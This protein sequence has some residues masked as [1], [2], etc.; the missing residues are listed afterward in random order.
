MSHLTFRRLQVVHDLGFTS[1]TEVLRL[2]GGVGNRLTV[3]FVGLGA[4]LVSKSVDCVV[5]GVEI[6]SDDVENVSTCC[7][8]GRFSILVKFGS[9]VTFGN[10]IPVLL[11]R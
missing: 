2:K 9:L 1:G 3:P 7:P 6:G 11:K 10:V 5:L 4:G 8:N